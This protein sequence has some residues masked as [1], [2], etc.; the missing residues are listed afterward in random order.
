MRPQRSP[1]FIIV[2]LAV[3]EKRKG[4]RRRPPNPKLRLLILTSDSFRSAQGAYDCPCTCPKWWAIK[5]RPGKVSW[6]GGPFVRSQLAGPPAP[7]ATLITYRKLCVGVLPRCLDNSI[8][9]VFRGK[10]NEM[11]G[12][13]KTEEPQNTV[14]QRVPGPRQEEPQNTVIQRVRLWE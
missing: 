3:R 4:P 14:M 2:M 12:A 13:R 10:H 5:M 1:D 9:Y 7:K 8:N 6:S 11:H